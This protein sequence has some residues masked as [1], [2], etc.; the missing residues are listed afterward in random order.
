M[1]RTV[2]GD[3][4]VFCVTEDVDLG[5]DVAHNLVGGVRVHVVASLA[6]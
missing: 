1:W 4:P 5:V 2:I 3:T 6:F